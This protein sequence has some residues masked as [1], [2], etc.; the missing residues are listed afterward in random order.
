MRV[1]QLTP[2]HSLSSSSSTSTSRVGIAQNTFPKCILSVSNTHL[3]VP[4]CYDDLDIASFAACQITCSSTLDTSTS[5]QDVTTTD[6]GGWTPAYR[7]SPYNGNEYVQVRSRIQTLQLDVHVCVHFTQSHEHTRT[8]G[9]LFWFQFNFGT[10]TRVSRVSMHSDD[11]GSW[12]DAFKLQ[13]ST[14]GLVWET[15]KDG[16]END[17]V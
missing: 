7:G 8:S 2:S 5:C 9:M 3:H 4:E 15:V 12:L 6:V 1:R 14:H 17:K 11:G 13:Y 10:V 16:D